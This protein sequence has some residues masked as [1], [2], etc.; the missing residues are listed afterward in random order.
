MHKRNKVCIYMF[1]AVML[2]Q[3]IIPVLSV[4]LET[5]YSS[6]SEAVVPSV[7]WNDIGKGADRTSA[8]LNLNTGELTITKNSGSGSIKDFEENDST[9]WEKNGISYANQ[10]KS[11]KIG[12]GIKYIGKYAFN[13]LENLQ[14]VS[15]DY[16]KN[17]ADGAFKNCINLKTIA[18]T[19]TAFIGKDAFRNCQA[20]ES[21][22]LKSILSVGD[23]AFQGCIRLS[24]RI[25]YKINKIG[26]K[27]F[28]DVYKVQGMKGN[29]NDVPIVKDAKNERKECLILGNYLTK[30]GNK[31]FYKVENL[32]GV[33]ITKKTGITCDEPDYD[34]LNTVFKRGTIL[35]I[36]SDS[37]FSTCNNYNKRY[38]KNLYWVKEPK[39]T[40]NLGDSLE[41]EDG[42][43][44]VVFFDSP[45]G[46][47]YL[48]SKFNEGIFNSGI[49]NG[50]V[51]EE[52]G[53][54]TIGI[55]WGDELGG[56]SH[57]H[58]QIQVLDPVTQIKISKKP[59]DLEYKLGENLD[60]TGMVV[61]AITN[62]GEE[63]TLNS[64]EYE[65]SPLRLEN[66]G[67]Q[68]I[69]VK[70][71]A[72]PDIK[73]TFYV[74]VTPAD[75]IAT[76]V[77]YPKTVYTVGE[78][79]RLE[80]LH[81]KIKY[82]SGP[83]E[84]HEEH[85]R[86]DDDEIETEVLHHGNWLNDIG[87]FN[88]KMWSKNEDPILNGMFDL[89]TLNIRVNPE[90]PEEEPE[91]PEEKQVKS[92]SIKRKPKT[93]YIVGETLSTEN[94]KLK[95]TYEDDSIEYITSGFTTNP[96]EG[97]ILTEAEEN[98]KVIVSYEEKTTNYKIDVT[99][100]EVTKIEPT[101]DFRI[102]YTKGDN[103]DLDGLELKV[104][105]NTGE[106]VIIKDG[107][108]TEPQNGTELNET[109]TK[110]IKI[111]YRGKETNIYIYIYERTLID[112]R[113]VNIGKIE[114]IEGE[115]F[116][117]EEQFYVY[118]IYNNE[119]TEEVFDYIVEDGENIKLGQKSVTIRYT[120]NNRSAT[121]TTPITVTAKQL[122]KIE[123]TNEPNKTTYV[124]GE[125]FDTTGMIITATYNNGRTSQINKYSIPNGQNLTVEMT[126]VQIVY[127][128]NG[129]TKETEQPIIVKEKEPISIRPIES[130]KKA[131]IEGEKIDKSEICVYIEYNDGTIEQVTNYEVNT[132]KI[133]SSTDNT[134]KITYKKGDITLETEVE[135][136]VLPSKISEISIKGYP[137]DL[138]YVVGQKFFSDG[139]TILVKYVDGT[140]EEITEG[141]TL[142]LEDGT[143]LTKAETKTITVDYMGK[144]TIFDINIEENNDVQAL[145]IIDGS[146]KI[147]YEIGEK[148]D[149][150]GLA[151]ISEDSNNESKVIWGSY[152]CEPAEGIELDTKGQ[153]AIMVNYAGKSA[154]LNI[155]VGEHEVEEIEIAN[156]P[157]TKYVIGQTLD[158]SDLKLKVIYDNG[159]E[160]IIETGYTSSIDNGTVFNNAEKKTIEIT[161]A[162]KTINF[163]IEIVEKQIEKL[164]GL[165]A[166]TKNK[167]KVGEK[168]DLSGV[169]LKAIYNDGEE[170]E[171]ETGFTSSIPEGTVLDSIGYNP[172]IL[173]YEGKTVTA[174]VFVGEVET[175]SIRINTEPEKVVYQVGEQLDLTG[176]SI[177]ATYENGKEDVIKSG[178]ETTPEEG[179]EL[180]ENGQKEITVRLG[181]KTATFNVDVQGK[182]ELATLTEIKIEKAPDK[183]K[184]KV[185]EKFDKTGM[186]VKA[187]YSDGSS[188]DVSN[189][190][191]MP[192]E[193]LE[194]ETTE[195]TII[196]TEDSI[197]K[198]AK[199]KIEVVKD[200][201]GDN[202]GNNGNDGNSGN[203]GNNNSENN[204]NNYNSNDSSSNNQNDSKDS[205]K[206]SGK[207]P[208]TGSNSIM[209]IAGVILSLISAVI[210]VKIKKLEI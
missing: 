23:Y 78:M 189:Y 59:S 42:K 117:T 140:E 80:G 53:T 97:T 193:Q 190:L 1:I 192:E 16:A 141:F 89:G 19:K 178:F 21:V 133:L 116:E 173:E 86:F 139:L 203:S 77:N 41:L 143:I 115:N 12:E 103:L 26:A 194:E 123:I 25:S 209:L 210:Y 145:T 2:L 164:K 132:M 64:S 171:I 7:I 196:Y 10:I 113:C 158:L 57:I 168:L 14:K 94:L 8:V 111:K 169:K 126:S 176:L 28:Y 49:K 144:E 88:I 54:K 95:V 112:L 48:N 11:I 100:K 65:C 107:F 71:K 129:V 70:Y 147:N 15:G 90:L 56:H 32:E 167:Y 202:Q 191:Y 98:K 198:Y 13:S 101:G 148:L 58:L 92:I 104:T 163:D 128:E 62:S 60:T 82:T 61:K 130:T 6:T 151:L 125:N 188:K 157:K 37:L 46:F 51:L 20:L 127:T 9:K 17:V 39:T 36:K 197:T 181:E 187:I 79:L 18:L 162:E 40:Y 150:D 179:E 165:S 155:T 118:A 154:V 50:T 156:L 99:E 136:L 81:V 122:E 83:F 131:Y 67:R 47:T 87:S 172:V 96:E 134:R 91:I 34:G 135:V 4:I 161:Y 182:K 33:V 152:E 24:V 27:A 29:G 174:L 110:P 146:A 74:T 201:G 153:Q 66:L 124:E 138:D 44:S 195:I 186:V 180:N 184:Y 166:P 114:Y 121:T 55:D 102:I 43:L 142:S 45:E 170:K 3:I 120:E 119:T 137:E 177:V 5:R 35:Y 109:G 63:I 52:P 208:Q 160:E 206:A 30:I 106:V 149:L 205:D 73:K 183:T 84:N 85:F 175:K 76:I 200:D 72:N 199:Q 108:T 38:E 68:K 22:N 185:G 93:E 207:I 204:N 105:Y 159:A 69:T 31:A 75:Y